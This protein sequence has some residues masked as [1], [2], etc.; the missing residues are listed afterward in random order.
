MFF[1]LY[2]IGMK[3]L[4]KVQKQLIWVWNEGQGYETNAWRCEIFL[5]GLYRKRLFFLLLHAN[6]RLFYSD[7]GLFRTIVNGSTLFLY[8]FHGLLEVCAVFMPISILIQAPSTFL[9]PEN[10]MKKTAV[11]P[12]F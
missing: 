12:I 3:I 1:Y 2:Q 6:K 11:R 9:T 5:V 8:L 10:G 7:L 4:Q